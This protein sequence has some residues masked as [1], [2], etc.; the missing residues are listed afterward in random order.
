[1]CRAEAGRSALP[2]PHRNRR[3]ARSLTRPILAGLLLTLAPL[4]ALPALG[5]PRREPLLSELP[6]AQPRGLS[7]AAL[8]ARRVELLPELV[9]VAG[10]RLSLLF[11]SPGK[12]AHERFGQTLLL[13]E[14]ERRAFVYE[15]DAP[16]SAPATLPLLRGQLLVSPE[17]RSY[18]ALRERWRREARGVMSAPLQLPLRQRQLLIA[19]LE[20]WLRDRR[21]AYWFDP[22]HQS[23]STQ[24]RGLLDQLTEGQLYRAGHAEP[25]YRSWRSDLRVAHRAR[26]LPLISSELLFGPSLAQPQ[27]LWALSYRAESLYHLLRRTSFQ[28]RPLVG[29]R[30]ALSPPL[31]R[32]LGS[33]RL[34][35]IVLLALSLLVWGVALFWS[36]RPQRR[37]RVLLAL[38]SGGSALA[39]AA[40]FALAL[41]SAWAPTRETALL[42]FTSPLD[43]LVTRAAFSPARLRIDPLPAGWAVARSYLTIRIFA[44]LP[45]LL[46]L[47]FCGGGA[48]TL[49][50]SMLFILLAQRAC[51]QAA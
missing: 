30:R 38:L 11:I 9:S 14:Q 7:A 4:G 10:E 49:A 24:L 12:A 6:A 42:L 29:A 17:R 47:Q 15:L 35:Q 45:A 22:L 18:Q 2:P 20:S 19:Q 37:L 41:D 3:S 1:M 46:F 21:R 32:P 36:R 5:A 28:G 43:L 34:G 25:P 33:A 44:L 50:L 51:L 48:L 27:Q 31:G 16:Q 13:R 8:E 26:W 23:G 39:N 40:L